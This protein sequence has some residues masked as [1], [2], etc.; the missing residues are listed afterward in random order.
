MVCLIFTHALAIRFFSEINEVKEHFYDVQSLEFGY[1]LN[2]KDVS[3]VSTEADCGNK[4]Q[5]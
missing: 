3:L 2:I 5:Y 1:L 4:W